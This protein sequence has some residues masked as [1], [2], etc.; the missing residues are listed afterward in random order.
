M[1]YYVWHCMTEYWVCYNSML[2]VISSVTSNKQ[3]VSNIADAN[4]LQFVLLVL[5]MLPSCERVCVCMY[6]CLEFIESIFHNLFCQTSLQV[7]PFPNSITFVHFL[8]GS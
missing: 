4:V 6:M 8:F 7:T 3:C 1:G 5:H 2:Q